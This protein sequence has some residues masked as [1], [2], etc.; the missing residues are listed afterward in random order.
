[1]QY[2]GLARELQSQVMQLEKALR[3]QQQEQGG[4]GA[5]VEGAPTAAYDV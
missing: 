1:M 3:A 4:V 2:V 5:E